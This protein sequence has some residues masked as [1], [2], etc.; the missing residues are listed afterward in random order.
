MIV[1]FRGGG[2]WMPNETNEKYVAAKNALWKSVSQSNQSLPFPTFWRTE[3][4]IKTIKVKIV[5]F[6]KF[7]IFRQI[8]RIEI[9]VLIWQSNQCIFTKKL[10]N[11]KNRN[12]LSH[13]TIYEVFMLLKVLA[14]SWQDTIDLLMH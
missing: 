10:A 3:N 8:G 12:F 7:K 4:W 14:K 13:K 2:A 1:K 11:S 6:Q 5:K 9:F